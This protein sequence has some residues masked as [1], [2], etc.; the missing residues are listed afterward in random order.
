V[1]S[2]TEDFQAG[3]LIGLADNI[4]SAFY[5]FRIKRNA[6]E[7]RVASMA[8]GFTTTQVSHQAPVADRRNE[9]RF[10]MQNGEA[11]AWVN[12]TQVLFKASP[13]KDLQLRP[14]T[15]LGLGAYNDMNTTVLRYR[16]IKV[17][18]LP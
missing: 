8:Y 1:R 9:F 17:R 4:R 15:L 11:D 3:I 12:G 18:Q 5:S 6:T 2:S 14:E 10:R 13:V 16:N 7:G